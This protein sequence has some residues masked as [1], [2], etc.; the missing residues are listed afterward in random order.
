L[1]A[2]P[3]P[4]S[5][6][7]WGV[8]NL[9]Q[10]ETYARLRGV[11]EDAA[12]NTAAPRGSNIQK[13]GDFYA[14]AVD[15]VN[16][17][18]QGIAPL[19]GDLAAID[20]IHDADGLRSAI[21]RLQRYG[22]D[23][24]YAQFVVQDEKNSDVCSF[25]L[26][27]GGLGLPNRDYYVNTDARTANIRR[28]YIAHVAAMFVLLGE[29]RETAARHSEVVMAIETALAKASRKLEDLRDPYRNYNRMSL[30][31]LDRL[32]PSLRWK[33]L[34]PAMAIAHVDS[35]VVGQPEFFREV[36]NLLRARPLEEWKDYLRWTLVNR[37]APTLSSPFEKE[38]F[39][40]YQTVLSGVKEPRPRWKRALDAE[41]RSMGD[42]LGQLF[43]ERYVPPSMK[44]RYTALVESIFAAYASRI[45]RLD[46]MS[47]AT[48]EKALAKLHAVTRKV[49]YPDRW[50]DYAALEIDRSSYCANQIRADVWDYNYHAS[51]LGKPVDRTEW[52]MT[53]QTYNAYYNPSNNEIVLPAA[54]LMIPGVA[55]SLVDDAVIYGYA[56]AST[57]GHEVTHGFD[58]EGRQFDAAG[59]LRNWWTKEDEVRFNAKAQLMV[60]QFQRYVVLDSLHV[61]GK[62]SLGENIADLGGVVI[63]YDA[64]KKTR[65]G[66]SDTLIDGLT[67][68][69]RFFLAYAYSWL[70]QIRDESLARQ[71][72][73]DVHAPQFLR[74]NGPLSDVPEF[75]RAFGVRPG[76]PMYRPD[77]LRVK[78]W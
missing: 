61:N 38:H 50:K 55:D 76:D 11:C 2:N 78:I 45:E 43:V 8:G 18:K 37:F 48:K 40:F 58:D 28:E 35:V 23:P 10:E 34:L 60:D 3:I 54:G 16:I 6:R 33:S 46:W 64:F 24:L 73:T 7:G 41:E 15:T 19:G 21:A 70:G 9:V 68:D 75:Y 49:C 17:E 26:Y 13:I 32:V 4:P 25:H 20:S 56:G 51:K 65:E 77:S 59:N 42:M 30:G 39:R 57:I 67:G 1:K 71:V 36:E 12:A 53:P 62:A 22:G 66:Q 44:Q 29:T 5:E 74:V 31:E 14:A 52:D 72:M 27:Q 47:A 63:G 69:Q